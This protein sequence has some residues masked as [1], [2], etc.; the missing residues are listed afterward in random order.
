LTPPFCGLLKTIAVAPALALGCK[1]RDPVRGDV[2]DV[3]TAGGV[4]EAHNSSKANGTHKVG[5]K[6]WHTFLHAPHAK[7]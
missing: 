6:R 2:S 4:G 7:D 1:T 3:T 5:A